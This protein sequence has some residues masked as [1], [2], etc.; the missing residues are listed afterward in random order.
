M[1]DYWKTITLHWQPIVTLADYDAKPPHRRIVAGQWQW[2]PTNGQTPEAWWAERLERDEASGAQL[3]IETIL[4]DYG[5]SAYE[6]VPLMI[7]PVHPQQEPMP[8]YLL[9]P[10]WTEMFVKQFGF[11]LPVDE[12]IS[13]DVWNALEIMRNDYRGRGDKPPVMVGSHVGRSHPFEQEYQRLADSPFDVFML[14]PSVIQGLEFTVLP[15]PQSMEDRLMSLQG[16]VDLMRENGKTVI[17]TGITTPTELHAAARTGCEFAQGPVFMPS[18]PVNKTF[19]EPI[20]TD[21]FGMTVDSPIMPVTWPN[22]A[23]EVVRQHGLTFI[24]QKLLD[25]VKEAEEAL[26]TQ[27]FCETRYDAAEARRLTDAAIQKALDDA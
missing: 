23:E 2:A 27:F 17:A 21:Q 8:G 22:S 18:T 3:Y 16:F 15:Q 26:Y 4:A 20:E 6:W 1:K 12:A 19:F 10:W 13:P 14:E 9:K 25:Q 11:E 5:R 24:N 7:L